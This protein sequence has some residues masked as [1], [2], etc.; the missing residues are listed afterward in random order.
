MFKPLGDD[1]FW[2]TLSDNIHNVHNVH[3][4]LRFVILSSM[5]EKSKN[6]LLVKLLLVAIFIAVIAI[7]LSYYKSP[8]SQSYDLLQV[9]EIS[10]FPFRFYTNVPVYKQNAGELFVERELV[11]NSD[12]EYNEL[13]KYRR[14][15]NCALP[16]VDFSQKTVFG[17]FVSGS[18]AATGFDRIYLRND[19][20][21]TITYSVKVNERFFARCSGPGKHS[22]NLI[23]VPKIPEGHSV[24]FKPTKPGPEDYREYR[25]D[26][27]SPGG[28]IEIDTY[29]NEIRRGSGAAENEGSVQFGGFSTCVTKDVYSLLQEEGIDVRG[30]VKICPEE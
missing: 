21:K 13:L 14:S 6:H 15:E 10:C 4:E 23:A 19:N 5:L 25:S 29:G 18:C 3:L 9:D 26:P 30:D 28:W 27:N 22:M 24:V 1:E 8:Q 12:D 17:N 20:N 7:G 16:P 2:H 11:L